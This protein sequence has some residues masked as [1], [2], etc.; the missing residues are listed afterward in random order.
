MKLKLTESQLERLRVA[1]L[2]EELEDNA[3]DITVNGLL[4][5]AVKHIYEA[6]R[7]LENASQ[8]INDL[9]LKKQIQDIKL[10]I[11]HEQENNYGTEFTHSTILSRLQ[12]I[13][14]QRKPP[15]TYS[16]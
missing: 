16:D 14:Q 6:Y 4:N 13:L 1:V 11:G 10:M 9:H 7:E 5:R 12:R 3:H 2:N 8:Y 15:E